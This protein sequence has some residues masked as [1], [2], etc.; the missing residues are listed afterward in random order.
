MWW[1]TAP[2]LGAGGA[3]PKD[4]GSVC[5]LCKFPADE[6]CNE[7]DAGEEL[8]PTNAPLCAKPSPTPPILGSGEQPSPL[9]AVPVLELV[10][11]PQCK[12]LEEN[13]DFSLCAWKYI[14][15]RERVAP[16]PWRGHR[17]NYGQEEASLGLEL[18]PPMSQVMPRCVRAFQTLLP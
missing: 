18:C 9:L 10:E 7:L 6:G 17:Q 1:G 3:L 8:P 2:V 15:M 13:A 16:L 11:T 14:R 4:Q 12:H 5:G